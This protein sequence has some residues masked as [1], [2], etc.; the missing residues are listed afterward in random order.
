MTLGQV[1]QDV[2]EILPHLPTSG[3]ELLGKPKPFQCPEPGGMQGAIV[4]GTFLQ[5]ELPLRIDL[6]GDEM[7]DPRHPFGGNL[8]IEFP[9]LFEPC[10]RAKLQRDQILRA[11]SDSMRD[12]RPRHHKIGAIFTA[13]S[14]HQM[15]MRPARIMVHGAD[16]F[17]ARAEVGFHLRNEVSDEGLEVGDFGAILGR[18]DEPE[19]MPVVGNGLGEV[20]H[21]RILAH[22]VEEFAAILLFKRGVPAN[23][24]DVRGKGGC[25]R[26][27]HAHDARLDDD[28]PLSAARG[29]TRT[30]RQGSAPNAAGRGQG[31]RHPREI[32]LRTSP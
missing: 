4:R 18:D 27:R 9:L 29:R 32:S 10:L 28:A 31:F 21:A 5:Q 2:P 1:S 25:A 17:E 6:P 8:G 14:D 26:R 11:L 22:G 24:S 12:V 30:S 7:I 23:V 15:R 19:M 13:S 20:G 16:P 3:A